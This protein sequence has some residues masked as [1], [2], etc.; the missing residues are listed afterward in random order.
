VPSIPDEGIQVEQTVE[1]VENAVD[2]IQDS[3]ET[4]A[5]EIDEPNQ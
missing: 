3:I 4:E 5:Q 1:P 2:A